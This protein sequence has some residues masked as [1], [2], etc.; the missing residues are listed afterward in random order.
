M[1]QHHELTTKRL[2]LRPFVAGD[3]EQLHELWTTAGVRRFLW[4]D[5][6]IPPA[7][8]IAAIEQS[9][10]LF[11]ERGFG[12][13]GAWLAQQPSTLA[14][15]GGLWPFREPP[16]LELLYGVAEL[17]WGRGHA[18]DIA[19]AVVAYCFAVLGMSS[20]GASTDVANVASI[21]VL[22]KLGAAFVRR[23]VV[24]G[25]DTVFYEVHQHSAKAVRKIDRR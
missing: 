8:T 13:W 11:R 15:F 10:T 7:R 21:R 22:E 20:V 18:T 2:A 12:L 1:L 24:D 5:E 6:V 23:A 9:Q 25:L 19:H 17:E 3:A 16:Q 14:G 4:D